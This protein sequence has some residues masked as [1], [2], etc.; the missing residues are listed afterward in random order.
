MSAEKGTL[1]LAE[2]PD[3]IWKQSWGVTHI[4]HKVSKWHLSRD[5]SLLDKFN[6]C[7]LNYIFIWNF[8][9]L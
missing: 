2:G 8:S 7:I 1:H 4:S 6:S 9:W 5:P 3:Y